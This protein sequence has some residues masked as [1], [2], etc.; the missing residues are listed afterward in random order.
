MVRHDPHTGDIT[1]CPKDPTIARD[2]GFKGC[3][4][5]YGLVQGPGH[6]DKISGLIIRPEQLKLYNELG[7]N[8]HQDLSRAVAAACSRTALKHSGQTWTASKR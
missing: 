7:A 5:C 6:S 2:Y 8:F 1:Y 4:T 3:H